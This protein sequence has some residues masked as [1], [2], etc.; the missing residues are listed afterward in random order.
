MK[1]LLV[2]C[3]CSILILVGCNNNSNENKTDDMIEI[4]NNSTE[5]TEE[6]A[7]ESAKEIQAI[8]IETYQDI[9]SFE[10]FKISFSDSDDIIDVNVEVDWIAIRKP[11]DNPI[12]QGMKEATKDITDPREKKKSEKIIEGFLKELVGEY[13]ETE[14]ISTKLKIEKNGDNYGI[15]YPEV[16]EGET[17]LYPMKEYYNENFKENVEQR[18]ELGRKTLIERLESEQSN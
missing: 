7:K 16:K 6:Q 10:N 8:M 4:E 15:M 3:L 14:R 9:Y 1:K 13:K 18:K 12:I 17:T 11:E 5:L 2:I